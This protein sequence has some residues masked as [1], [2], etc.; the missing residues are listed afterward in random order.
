VR[1]RSI[2]LFSRMA[3][4]ALLVAGAA[5]AASRQPSR[6]TPPEPQRPTF[7]TEANF[8]RVDVYPTIG[9]KPLLDLRKEEFEVLEDGR[10]QAIETFEHVR[11]SAGSAPSER[12]DPGSLEAMR[13]AAANPRSRIFVMFL[14]APH[15]TSDGARN[16]GQALI[17]FLDRTLAPD[18]LVGVMTPWMSPSDVVLA[19][20]TQVVES[21]LRDA[22]WGRR[23]TTAEDQREAMYKACY[24][25]LQQEREQG[26]SVSDLAKVL[27]VR[28]RE[29]LSL[30]ALRDL[31]LYL[32]DVREERKAILV[33][34][35][36]WVLFRPDEQITRLRE[37]CTC[38]RGPAR[39]DLQDCRGCTPWPTSDNPWKEPVPGLDPVGVGPDGRLR[40]G[41]VD[42]LTGSVAL[43]DCNADRMRLANIDNF[44]FARDLAHDANRA[45]ATFYTVDP[46]GLA[47]FDMPIYRD[48]DE[49]GLPA[50]VVQDQRSMRSRH[51]AMANLASATDG[52]AVM[53]SNDLD[54]GLR[55]IAEDLGAYY[56][57][58]Y[59]STN[60]KLDG[61]FR[62]IAVRVKRPGVEIRARR[63]YRAATEAEVAAAR[64]AI[65][66]PMAGPANALASALAALPRVGPS[67]RFR[68]HAVAF[69]STDRAPVT[70]V[71]IAGELPPSQQGWGQGGSAV[72]DVT[73]AG[74]SGA[75]EVALRAGERA[76][77]TSIP[78]QPAG[79]SIDIRGRLTNP[80][81]A[82]TPFIENIRLDVSP[83]ALP[84]PLL[85]R[86]GPSTGNRLQPAAD[87]QFS[88]T[89]R[90]RLELPIHPGMKPGPARLLD[91]TGQALPVPVAV[92]ERTD[93]PAGQRWLTADITLAALGAGDYVVELSAPAAGVA[94]KTLTA[95]RVTR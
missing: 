56:L 13:Q 69:R 39:R 86:R 18:D 10:P 51:D 93:S 44:Q 75:V 34:T 29:V 46:R 53:N 54:A 41:R 57:L 71:W 61:R 5:A 8:V 82:V 95:I 16:I 20:K 31:V 83:G 43:N 32:R 92:G 47:V 19:R 73:G 48:M 38:P 11:I 45:N 80:D 24:R 28:R 60:P 74:V 89:D 15:V 50:D 59:Y 85:F 33:V 23:F 36:G 77:L 65:P 21:G 62:T 9:G 79:T 72:I 42:T 1:H 26:K 12:A 17:R 90:A 70:M 3:A 68:M 84:Q 76:F 52:I 81:P 67:A 88:R 30:E 37:E 6:Q 4:A 58:G 25:V 49:V 63:G 87:F 78:I 2:G 35:E 94:Q 64:T 7:R 22:S 14:D 91:R 66:P 55:R 27:T 40:M